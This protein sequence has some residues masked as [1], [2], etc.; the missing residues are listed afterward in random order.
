M[1]VPYKGPVR[2]YH[3]GRRIKILDPVSREVIEIAINSGAID[4]T[5]RLL[6]TVNLIIDLLNGKKSVNFD[7]NSGA[8]EVIDLSGETPTLA[9]TEGGIENVPV[10]SNGSADNSGGLVSQ[11][12]KALTPKRKGRPPKKK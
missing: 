12:V 3:F 1:E 7:K 9:M 2:L 10:E 8:Y 5:K 6:V 11:V 4:Y